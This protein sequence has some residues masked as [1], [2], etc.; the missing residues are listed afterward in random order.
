MV[1]ND[2]RNPQVDAFIGQF[3]RVNATDTALTLIDQTILKPAADAIANFVTLPMIFLSGIFFPISSAPAIVKLIGHL[4]PLT[5]LANGLRDVAVRGDS[6][7]STMNDVL[8][9][10]LFS[11]VL[12]L[13]SLRF[14]RWESR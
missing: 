1:P 13:V 9:L 2:Q 11:G 4:M 3:S 8:V 10:A 14:F 6:V 7:A 5:Y 12:A